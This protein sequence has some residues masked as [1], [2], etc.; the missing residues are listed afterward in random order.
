MSDIREE[1]IITGRD[2]DQKIL[3]STRNI[4]MKDPFKYLNDRL[5]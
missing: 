3:L 4:L 5:P 1:N 2:V